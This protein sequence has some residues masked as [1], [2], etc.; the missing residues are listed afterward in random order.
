MP[1]RPSPLG[2]LLLPFAVLAALAAPACLGSRAGY[3]RASR[4][5][6]RTATYREHLVRLRDQLGLT[7]E[8]LGTLRASPDVLPRSNRETFQTFAREL[9]NLDSAVERTRKDYGRMD[10]GALIFFGGWVSD[11]AAIQDA[12]LKKRAEERRIAL[13]ANYQKVAQGHGELDAALTRHLRELEDLRVYLET[14]LTPAGI[15]SVDDR[16]ARALAV[17]S[18]LQERVSDQAHATDAAQSGLTPLQAQA[19]SQELREARVR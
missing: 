10:E 9:T 11:T 8:A 18:E 3:E 2:P 14:D 12:D 4:T 5:A 6:D 16:I 13:Q 17:S 1:R 7:A 19:P 15:T